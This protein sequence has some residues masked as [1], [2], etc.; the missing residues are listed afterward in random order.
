M[1]LARRL[2]RAGIWLVAVLI[3][4]YQAGLALVGIYIF[5]SRANGL[6]TLALDSPLLYVPALAIAAYR[7]RA[8][9][10]AGWASFA[11]YHAALFAIAWPHASALVLDLGLDWELLLV[12][13]LLTVLL[14]LRARTDTG[15]PV[16]PTSPRAL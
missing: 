8:G 14:Y 9:V 16:L 6:E 3:V 12:S 4:A 10:Y 11:V 7:L 2:L 1:P 13:A 5:H 15:T